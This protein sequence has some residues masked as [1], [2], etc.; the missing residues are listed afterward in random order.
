M[1]SSISTTCSL[2]NQP[3][4]LAIISY[5]K[6]DATAEPTT[7]SWTIDDSACKNED[8]AKTVP[9]FALKPPVSNVTKNIDLSLEI[10]ST[11]NFLW[12]LDGSS[13]RTDY[14]N[15]ILPLLQSKNA[16]ANIASFP[17]EWNVYNFGSAK[18]FIIQIRNQNPIAHPFHI[19]G[20]N[21]FVLGEGVGTWDGVIQGSSSN[22][23]RRD[24]ILLQPSGYIAIQVDADNPGIWPFHCHIAWHVS[25]GLYLNILER[26]SDIPDTCKSPPE[27]EGL[28]ASWQAF[29]NT[30]IV[31]QIDSGLRRRSEIDS[32]P[33][34]AKRRQHLR[35]HGH[36][37]KYMDS[38]L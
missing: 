27:F 20:H 34:S 14:N 19:H 10:N 38:G 16:T 37:V 7:S 3:D 36:G 24:V 18:S 26:P 11:G 28:C 33:W 31:D 12:T 9:F 30:D 32:T 6:A 25:G 17:S 21:M 8:L 35:R 15:P 13:F 1:R 4:A 22:P 29:T 2:T 5:E 23:A